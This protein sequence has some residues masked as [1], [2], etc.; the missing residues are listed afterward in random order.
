MTNFYMHFLDKG[1]GRRF[2]GLS[3]GVKTHYLTLGGLSAMPMLVN[4]FHS[5]CV[6]NGDGY[7]TA[8]VRWSFL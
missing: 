7:L 5:P 4:C 3:L 8:D 6:F 2:L 1:V